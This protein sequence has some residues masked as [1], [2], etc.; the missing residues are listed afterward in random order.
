MIG[1]SITYIL[2]AMVGRPLVHFHLYLHQAPHLHYKRRIY[3][4][5][6]ELLMMIT[7]YTSEILFFPYTYQCFVYKNCNPLLIKK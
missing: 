7:K 4:W 5:R 2:V 6:V 3:W 1:G